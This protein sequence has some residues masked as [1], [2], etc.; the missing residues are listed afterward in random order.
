MIPGR[1]A[2]EESPVKRQSS[3]GRRN[4]GDRSDRPVDEPAWRFRVETE[5][6][7]DGRE[8]HYHSWPDEDP[9]DPGE[10]RPPPP[11]EPTHE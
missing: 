2:S 6:M 9:D 1:T 4:P 11:A 8:I 5:A 7:P 3:P 10:G